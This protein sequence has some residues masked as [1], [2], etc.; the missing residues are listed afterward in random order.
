MNTE[1]FCVVKI[2]DDKYFN[3]IFNFT[4]N[5]SECISFASTKRFGGG[6]EVI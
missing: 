2:G 6:V 1:K 5:M 4:G 3:R